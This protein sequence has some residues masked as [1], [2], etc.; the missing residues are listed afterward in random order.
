MY[1]FYK[2]VGC[3]LCIWAGEANLWRPPTWSLWE[4]SNC[5]DTWTSREKYV[6]RLPSETALKTGSKRNDSETGL[7]SWLEL[8]ASEREGRCSQSPVR[9]ACHQMLTVNSKPCYFHIMLSTLTP[10]NCILL[11]N[12]RCDLYSPFKRSQI[13]ALGRPPKTTGNVP[14]KWTRGICHWLQGQPRVGCPAFPAGVSNSI[15]CKGSGQHGS[16]NHHWWVTIDYL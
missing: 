2:P 13:W 9:P 5:T 15:R 7:N 11:V 6:L 4:A 16:I 10:T 14:F 12:L 8:A 3:V 1:N